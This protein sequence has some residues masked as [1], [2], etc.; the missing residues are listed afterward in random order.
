VVLLTKEF[1]KWVVLSNIIAWP[2]AY[3][4]M[5]GWLSHF[6]YRTRL[7]VPVFALSTAL[8]LVVALLTVG[9]QA[10]KAARA[11]PV[12]SLRYE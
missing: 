3:L 6:A 4:A 11:N 5:R 7:G 10:F 9:Y 12:D 1:L 2:V 8:A